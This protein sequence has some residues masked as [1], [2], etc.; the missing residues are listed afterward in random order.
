[1]AGIMLAAFAARAFIP[2]GFMPSGGGQFSM[3][4]C[5]E[6]LPAELFAR[7]APASADLASTGSMPGG[8]HHHHES[9]A[10]GE[11]CVFGTTCG[12][13]PASHLQVLGDFSAVPPLRELGPASA[14]ALVP[15]VHLP[16][17]RAPP[18]Q[19]S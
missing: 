2:M 19:R 8:H 11:H 13:G 5:P 14:P 18:V 4:I 10:R 15:V 9:P 6:G 1:M 16:P 17:P 3:E 12:A 7:I